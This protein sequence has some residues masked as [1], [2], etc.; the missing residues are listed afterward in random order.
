MLSKDGKMSPPRLLPPQR[1]VAEHC[2]G[3]HGY[4]AWMVYSWRVSNGIVVI[5]NNLGRLKASS[6]S[7]GLY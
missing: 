1:E 6:Y 2:E 4:W 7:E 5:S 3:Q